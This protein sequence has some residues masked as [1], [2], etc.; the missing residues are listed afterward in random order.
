MRQQAHGLQRG[1]EGQTDRR[2]DE[3]RQQRPEGEEP[4]IHPL[5][6]KGVAGDRHRRPDMPEDHATGNRREQSRAGRP[7]K[8]PD[9]P[10]PAGEGTAARV[11]STEQR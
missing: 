7:A 1:E 8:P 9:S 3:I 10:P 5:V 11:Q 4:Q 6:P 2:V